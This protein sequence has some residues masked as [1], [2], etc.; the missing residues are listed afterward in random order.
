MEAHYAARQIEPK[1]ATKWNHRFMKASQVVD[2]D[3]FEHNLRDTG[4]EIY[5]LKEELMV[6]QDRIHELEA[7]CRS[8]K[9]QLDH[10]LKNLAEEKA[11]W[12]SREHGKVHHIVDAV[13]EELNRQRKQRAYRNDEFQ[14]PQ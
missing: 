13:K 9:K 2:D 10:L 4:G 14:T 8:T 5:S 6:A 11:S 12:K 7:E 3:Y 1:M